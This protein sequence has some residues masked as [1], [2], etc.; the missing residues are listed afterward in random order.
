ML[1]AVFGGG[2]VWRCESFFL[3]EVEDLGDGCFELII[4]A[5]GAFGEVFGDI[6][7]GVDAMTFLEPGAIG[8]VHT[9]SRDRDRAT[10]DETRDAADADEATPGAGADEGAETGFTEIVREGVSA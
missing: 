4:D 6:D 1:V 2:S 3:K 9:K 10:V 7:I 8:V 5:F